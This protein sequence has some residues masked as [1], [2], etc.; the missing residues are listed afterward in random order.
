MKERDTLEAQV[1]VL[2]NKIHTAAQDLIPAHAKY[3]VGQEVLEGQKNYRISRITAAIKGRHRAG[4]NEYY[5]YFEYWGNEILKSG[6]LHKI[7]RHL[8]WLSWN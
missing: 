6:A 4:N 2:N 8:Y 1:F 5:L 7:E 3:Q